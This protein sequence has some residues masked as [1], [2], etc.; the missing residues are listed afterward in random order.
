LELEVVGMLKQP[1]RFVLKRILYMF[2][3]MGNIRNPAHLFL[4]L[5]LHGLT[6]FM[7]MSSYSKS[8]ILTVFIVFTKW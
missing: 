3:S 7:D 1:T 8:Q 2:C 5:D 4:Q 6:Y